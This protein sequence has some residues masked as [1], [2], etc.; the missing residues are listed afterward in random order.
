MFKKI[1]SD[2]G[3][4]IVELVT[5]IVVIGILISTVATMSL[6]IQSS[7]RRANYKE[8]ANRAA[9]RQ[10]EALR[11]NNYNALIAGATINFT[12]SLPDSLPSNKQGLVTVSEPL[13]GLKRVDVAVTYNDGSNA[14]RV[15]LSSLIGILGIT[16]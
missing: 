1:D 6:Y 15:E 12:S 14:E 7:Q 4:T 9:Q 16:Q 8:A 13:P 10:V 11:N 2:S 5:T 3:F